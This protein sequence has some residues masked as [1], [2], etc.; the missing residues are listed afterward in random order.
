M[1]H[2]RKLLILIAALVSSSA[3][4]Q[5]F[6]IDG[7]VCDQNGTPVIG[8]SVINLPDKTNGAIT[9]IDG[10]FEI[11][12]EENSVLEISCIGY[13]TQQV[14]VDGRRSL[15]IILAD[16]AEFLD[17]VVVIGY[18]TIRKKDLTGAVASVDDKAIKDRPVS[19]VGQALQGKVAGV[20]IIDAGKPG[21][22]VTIRVRGLGTINNSE[23]LIVIDGV[24]T[25]LGLSAINTADIDRIDPGPGDLVLV[26]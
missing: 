19:N 5:T 24:P 21:N 6:R 16:N 8:A 1:K 13:E 9:D 18:G 20:Q 23:P 10:R 14:K 17:E 4:A 22:N 15:K 26:G 3:F 12:A 7:M 25:D 2:V 11:D